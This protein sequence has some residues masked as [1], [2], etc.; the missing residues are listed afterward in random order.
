MEALREDRLRERDREDASRELQKEVEAGRGKGSGRGGDDE[1]VS[2]PY[3]VKLAIGL[4]FQPLHCSRH[5]LY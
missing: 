4:E 2:L 3:A 1:V 5:Q